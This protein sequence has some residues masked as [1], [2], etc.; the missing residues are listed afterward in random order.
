[1]SAFLTTMHPEQ[2]AHKLIIIKVRLWHMS[3]SFKTR[4]DVMNQ[5]TIGKGQVK[6]H[7]LLSRQRPQFYSSQLSPLPAVPTRVLV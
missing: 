7:F 6:A 3:V 1:M 4:K 5:D 2:Y